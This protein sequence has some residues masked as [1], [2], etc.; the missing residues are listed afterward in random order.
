MDFPAD[1]AGG[2]WKKF[3]LG[4][5]KS[6]PQYESHLLSIHAEHPQIS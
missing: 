2:T 1:R 5:L 6:T 3:W 4:L